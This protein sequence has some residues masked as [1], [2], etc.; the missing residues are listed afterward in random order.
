MPD[1]AGEEKVGPGS[2]KKQGLIT[3]KYKW[4]VVGGLGLIAVLVFVFVRRSNANASGGTTGGATT[5]MDPATQAALQSAL[6]GQAAAGYAYQAS[7][8]PQGVPGPAGPA[9]PPGPS[10]ATGPTGKP[11]P[12]AKPQPMKPAPKPTPKPPPTGSNTRYYTV[13]AGDSL[14][15]IAS[16]FHVSGGWQTLYA[17]NR[18]AVGSNPNLIHPGLRLKIP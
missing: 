8:G 15:K 9:G 1:P 6:Q 5:A 2:N 14:S 7:T 13:K 10:G 12:I 18:N 17:S 11:P 4:Y 16:Q 3:G